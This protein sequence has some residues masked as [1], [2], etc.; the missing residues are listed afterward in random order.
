MSEYGDQ[1]SISQYMF[2]ENDYYP[3]E[4][5]I[6]KKFQIKQNGICGKIWMIDKSFVLLLSEI[7]VCES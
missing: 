2:N 3:I 1:C 5:I 4:E 6:I 7:H